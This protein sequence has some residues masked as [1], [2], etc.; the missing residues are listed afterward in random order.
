MKHPNGQSISGTSEKFLGQPRNIFTTGGQNPKQKKPHTM[1]EQARAKSRRSRSK[2]PNA[3]D[4][5][6][7]SRS[8]SRSREQGKY[9]IIYVLVQGQD[10]KVWASNFLGS[11]VCF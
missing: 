7:R 5:R 6:R 1:T 10:I 9:Q 11:Y 4:V 8:R 2:S 3:A